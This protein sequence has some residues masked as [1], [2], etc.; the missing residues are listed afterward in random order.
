MTG[1]V[2]MHV[3]PNSP[4][5]MYYVNLGL[6]DRLARTEACFRPR[7]GVG[8]AERRGGLA[9]FTPPAENLSAFFMA[10]G[11]VIQ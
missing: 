6:S 4:D 7:R 8:G 2:Q 11:F 1:Y 9:R 5:N 10:Y 3:V